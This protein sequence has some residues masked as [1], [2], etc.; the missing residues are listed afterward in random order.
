M[1]Q[2]VALVTGATAGVGLHT[3]IG[4]ARAGFR[5]L[6]AGRDAT[7]LEHARRTVSERAHSDSTESVPVETV[8]GDFAS[9]AAV[10]GIADTV[11]TRHDRLDVLVN[12]AGQIMP[13]Y[14]TSADGFELTLAVNHLAPFLLTNLLIDRLRGSTPSRII[15]VASIAHRG[16]RLDL[17]TWT[18]PQGWTP[19]SAYGR[20]KLCNILFTR[21]LARRLADTDIVAACL[22]PGVISTKIGDS[23]GS[24]AGW[25]WRFIKPFLTNP[26]KGATTTLFLATTPDIERFR[27]AYVIGKRSAEP[28]R[29]ARDDVLGEELWRESARLVGLT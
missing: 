14:E 16:A 20:S 18:G 28:D 22:H 27:G 9:L 19:L 3:A 8:L 24:I 13:R 26:E 4:L 10:H 12:N 23:A 6:I 2:P 25:G 29:A 1:P 17:A 15:N 21:A 11:L 5:V 7:R